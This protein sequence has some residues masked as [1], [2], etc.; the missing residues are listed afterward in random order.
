MCLRAN[1]VTPDK[2]QMWKSVKLAL[3]ESN[4][5]I[6]GSR[7]DKELVEAIQEI[8][9]EWWENTR[10]CL[11]R[12]VKCQKHVDGN[13]NH[14]YIL[15]LGNFTGGALVFDDGTRIEGTEKYKFHKINGQIPHWNED[16][17]GTKYS[18]IIYQGN[19]EKKKTNN[20]NQRKNEKK[21]QETANAI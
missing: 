1:I 12:N 4:S 8:A 17:E 14:S 11:N 20:I 3:T 21:L 19:T 2:I 9:P 6:K 10:V 5:P 18:I 15:W 13:K 7:H 16:H